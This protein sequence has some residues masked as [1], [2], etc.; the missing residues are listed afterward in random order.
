MVAPC[1][2]VPLPGG[3]PVPSGMT[4]MSQAAISAGEIGWPRLGPW[5]N[6]ALDP[7]ASAMTTAALRSLCVNMFHLA[8]P[9]DSPARGAVVMLA[10]EG[11]RVRHRCLGLATLG[12]NLGARRLHV[13]RFVPRT[14]L[15][16]GRPAIPAPRHAEPSER[17]GKH[18]RLQR[19]LRPALAA[20]GRDH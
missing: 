20:V 8:I 3:S 4:L 7:S 10:W 19:R 2:G 18:R 9:L 5:A 12:D 13:A 11:R 6:A 14:A 16:N 15:Q 1:A 17:L